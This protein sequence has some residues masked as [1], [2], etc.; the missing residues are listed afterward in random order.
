MIAKFLNFDYL[1]AYLKIILHLL[2][3]KKIGVP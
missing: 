2:N 3:D 1:T